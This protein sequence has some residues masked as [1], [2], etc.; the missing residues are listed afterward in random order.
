MSIR[1]NKARADRLVREVHAERRARR[2]HLARARGI[3]ERRLSSPGGL[4][5]CFGLG[6]LTGLR[7]GRRSRSRDH[8]HDPDRAGDDDE[9]GLFARLLDSPVG[10]IAVRL[11]TATLLRSILTSPAPG[12]GEAGEESGSAAAE[13]AG[14]GA[15]Y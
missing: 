3:F 12:A 10:N 2:E 9:Q 7:L 13:M 14:D 1:S 15:G 6:A 8:D 4:A 11:A 5:V